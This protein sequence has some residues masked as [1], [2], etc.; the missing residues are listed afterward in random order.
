MQET[1][2]P[3]SSMMQMLKPYFIVFFISGF[4]MATGFFLIL[5]PLLKNQAAC[6]FKY[7]V[8]KPKTKGNLLPVQL[9]VE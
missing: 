8:N 5:Y 6:Y 9:I 3:F 2:L 4:T 1:A 7:L